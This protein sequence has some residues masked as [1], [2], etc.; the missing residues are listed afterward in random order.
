M[1]G[2]VSVE[3]IDA[4]AAGSAPRYVTGPKR[5]Q[6]RAY[7]TPRRLSSIDSIGLHHLGPGLSADPR[8]GQTMADRAVWRAKR[9]PYHVW[10]QP[11]LVVLAWGFERVTWHGNALNRRS[12][13]L[14]AAGNF[15]ALE[16]KREAHHDDPSAYAEALAV[17]LDIVRAELPQLRLLLTHSQA[18]RKPADPG[19]GIARIA[20]AAGAALLPPLT[21]APDFHVGNG[22]PWPS[23]WRLPL[24]HDLSLGAA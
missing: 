7:R 14:V 5:G 4:R 10:C 11:G 12:V 21:P 16:A 22:S 8:P 23:S 15:P 17:A 18:A 1:R 3:V 19:E 24:D 6:L 20:T 2:R 9:Q 13:G